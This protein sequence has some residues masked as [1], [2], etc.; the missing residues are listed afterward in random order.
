M[1]RKRGTRVLSIRTI[2]FIVILTL[3]GGM[4]ATSSLVNSAD[5]SQGKVAVLVLGFILTFVFAIAIG[6][7]WLEDT[8]S[9]GEK[10]KHE[11]IVA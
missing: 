6:G 5:S 3:C 7:L 1:K 4:Y 8:A 11:D 9:I 2:W 10:K